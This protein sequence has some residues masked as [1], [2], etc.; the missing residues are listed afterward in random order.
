MCVEAAKKA[1]QEAAKAVTKAAFTAFLA[2][3]AKHHEKVAKQLR[4]NKSWFPNEVPP[5][6]PPSPAPSGHT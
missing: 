1:A 6:P 3:Q 5:L 4:V 2:R